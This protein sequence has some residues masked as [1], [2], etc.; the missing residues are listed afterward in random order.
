[1]DYSKGYSARYILAL[2]NPKTWTEYEEYEFTSATIS[3]QNSSDLIESATIEM[4][5]EIGTGENY[6]R[7]YLE[8]IQN[9]ISERIALFTGLATTPERKIKGTIET[10]SIDAYSILKNTSD[11]ILPIGYY[12]PVGSG[13]ELVKELLSDSPAPISIEGTSPV[14]SESIVAS[15]GDTKLDMISEIL[16]AINWHI[17]ISGDGGIKIQP[18][19]T[20]EKVKIG[21]NNDLIETSV[22][23]SED[24]YSCPNVLIAIT[25]SDG[26]ATVKDEDPES[27]FS[28]V[29]RGREIWE[30]ETGVTLSD[31][32]NIAEY[33]QRRLKE[34][35]E[36]SKTL[37]YTRRF[38]PE[39]TVNDVVEINYP[40]QKL[41]G[42]YR[43]TSQTLK[44]GYACKTSE[45][46][47]K[48]D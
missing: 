11:V 13:A 26:N 33:A 4:T 16:T 38:A 37:S 22:T 32:E 12:A 7:L 39:A 29:S 10:Y 34:L 14:I 30:C 45:E 1:M 15:N 28:I 27:K 46:V 48:I 21:A 40:G 9:G 20:D 31:N 25:E 41:M 24:W 42:K 3:K 35:Q 5:E 2:I 47:V 17:R 43:V 44:L 19:K 23:E 6:I 18:Y 36:P 8:A